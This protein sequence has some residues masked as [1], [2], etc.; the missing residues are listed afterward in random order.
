M[1]AR[2]VDD[3]LS[4]GDFACGQ[5]P[6]VSDYP[7]GPSLK[8]GRDPV[9]AFPPEQA[10]RRWAGLQLMPA[11][12]PRFTLRKLLMFLV[13]GW[14]AVLVFAVAISSGRAP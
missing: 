2:R 5:T 9:S 6:F 4:P 13:L 11:R 14:L 3:L 10:R 7:G 12:R 8:L 1:A